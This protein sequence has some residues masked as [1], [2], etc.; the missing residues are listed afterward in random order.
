[1]SIFWGGAGHAGRTVDS[2]QAVNRRLDS[3]PRRLAFDSSWEVFDDKPT[4]VPWR[5]VADGAS[6]PDAPSPRRAVAFFRVLHIVLQILVPCSGSVKTPQIASESA[7]CSSTCRALRFYLKSYYRRLFLRPAPH[8]AQRTSR[9]AMWP[10]DWPASVRFVLRIAGPYGGRRRVL[11]RGLNCRPPAAAVP[12]KG[13]CCVSLSEI[14]RKLLDRCLARKPKAWEDFV[15]RYMGLVVHVI[16]HTAKCRSVLLTSDDRD[17]LASDVFF[18]IVDDDFAVLRRFRGKSSLATYLTVVSRR[19]VVHS[20]IKRRIS[21]PIGDIADEAAAHHEEL[22]KRMSDRDE[23]ERLLDELSGDDAAI[24]RMYHLDGKSY[25]EISQATGVP[26]NS[27]GP[28]LSR[29][30]AKMRAAGA[31][32]FSG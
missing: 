9:G 14:D 26:E 7:E 5:P 3:A 31:D 30:R 28:T 22:E 8:A 21:I 4:S 25:H 1:M 24:V 27:I 12:A 10:L 17:D 2:L 15:D 11:V 13:C 18:A 23:V 32:Q 20:L 6:A 16:N 19:V 29:A